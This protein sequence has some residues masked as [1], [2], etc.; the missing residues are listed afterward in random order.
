MVSRSPSSWPRRGCRRFRS[1]RSLICCDGTPPGWG[2]AA[3][4][5]LLVTVPCER[6]SCGASGC[7]KTP[8][9]TCC[10]GCRCFREAS[11][12]APPLAVAGTGDGVGA[13]VAD[14]VHALTEQS[15]GVRPSTGPGRRATGCSRMVRAVGQEG[16]TAGKRREVLDRLVHYC[17]GE[18][19]QLEGRGLPAAGIGDEIANDSALYTTAVEHAVATEQTELGLRLVHD[20]FLVWQGAA[21]RVEP[22]PV[23]ERPRR[24]DDCAEPRAQHGAAPPSDHRQRVPWGRRASSA[25]ARR[26]GG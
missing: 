11:G 22:R 10:I 18:L 17:I 2:T 21:Q 19:A 3:V 4:V 15:L 5:V 12:W 1:A 6:R 8:S 20:L 9:A 7:F 14:A 16:L 25:P 24:P 23:D 13:V 26:G